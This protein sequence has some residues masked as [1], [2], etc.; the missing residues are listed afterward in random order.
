MSQYLQQLND[1]Q[2]QAVTQTDGPVLVVA[3]PGSGKTRVLTFRIAHL[4]EQGTAP[5]D[6]LALTFTNKAARE[7]KERIAKVVGE[8]ANKVWAGTFHSIFARILRVEAEKIGYPSNFTI[9]DSEDTLNVIKA[10]LKE[11]NLDTNLYNPNA[12]R[13][14]I[15]SAKS[16]LITPTLYEKDEELR[17]Q[18]RFAKRP[19]TYAIYQKYTARCKRSGAM[20]FDDLLYRLYELFQKNPDHVIDKYRQKFKYILVDEFQ[21]TNHLQYAL[22][23]KFVE[24]PGSNRNICVVG[25][26]AQSI[27]A[28]RGA[29]IQNILDFEKDFKKHGIKVF[30]LEQ[31][32]R[33]TDHI[34]K[35]A[36]QIISYNSRQIP[37]TIWSD[38]GE[39]HRIKVIKALTDG[40]EGKRI[41][42]TI[43]EQKN[44]FHLANKDIA[45]LYRTN[46]QSRV[47]EEYLRRYNIPYRIFGGLSFYQ[48]KEVKDLIAYL[49]LAVNP[50]DDEAL[51]RVINQPK[52]GIGKASLDK[53]SALA[54]SAD[55]PLWACLGSAQLGKRAQSAINDFVKMIKNFN[56]R[57][58]KENAFELAA[59]IAKRS[60]IIDELKKDNTIE[61]MGRL[62][63]V[64]ALL[65]GISAF[66]DEDTVIDTETVPDKSLASYLQNIAL[67]TDQDQKDNDGDHVTLM[68]VHAAKGLEFKSVFVVGLEEKLFPSFMSMETQE[69]LDE[70]R[71]LFYVAITRA[72][73]YLTVSYANSR[74]RFGQMRYNEPSR[75]LEEIP[76]H[77]VEST[78]YVRSRS[79]FTNETELGSASGA[80]KA[81][82]QG[83]FKSRIAASQAPRVDPGNFKPS[84]SDAIQTGM[85]VL[86]L[87]FGEGKVLSIDG[88]AKNRVATIFFKDAG[89][90]QQRRIMLKFAKLQILG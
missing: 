59:D 49:R 58:N 28:F 18:D 33:S 71:R 65:D 39:G 36:N 43:L 16:N 45:I 38:K 12:I 41:A 55:K 20:D 23:R 7:M 27:Y 44:R 87:K 62:E 32:Y 19:Y 84:P 85:K 88:N 66:V 13:S 57:L 1:V 25:D 68:S 34:V 80:N 82:L 75:F 31:N 40:E 3:G 81:R 86:H 46:A 24:Y 79:T 30:K 11:M 51:R 53:I 69:G 6:I 2:R 21:D 42:D 56:S 89:D 61:G 50:N 5:W 73:Q 74:Y 78:A 54:N 90:P 48:R 37:K 26:D 83:N 35:A 70:E 63:N 17:Q 29:T 60:K 52:R 67:L 14:R 9:Y 4:I 8:R 64:N 76:A 47:F 10:I 15:S 77:H 22:V 72:E